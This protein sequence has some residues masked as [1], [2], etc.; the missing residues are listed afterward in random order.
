[1]RKFRYS[2]SQARTQDLREGGGQALNIFPGKGGGNCPKCP[3]RVKKYGN[4]KEFYLERWGQLPKLPN[5]GR[6]EGATA[7]LP[8]PCVGACI[9]ICIYIY[10]YIYI[11]TYIYTGPYAGWGQLGSC[12]LLSARVGQFGQLPPPL[13]VKFFKIPILFNTGWALWAIAPP[14]SGK[15]VKGLPPPLSEIL[16]T[17]L[18]T[19]IP[20]FSQSL[21]QGN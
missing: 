5:P 2:S 3:T 21:L 20:E 4:F 18:T 14:L 10:I 13:Q 15:N 19:A 1:M 9:Y 12:P 16:R 17:G 6:E 8:P 7:Q 11:Y